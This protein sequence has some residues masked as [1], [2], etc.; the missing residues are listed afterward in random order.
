ME[1][2]G[3]RV[4]FL[5]LT[6][7]ARRLALSLASP[8]D[9]RHHEPLPENGFVEQH[10]HD[11]DFMYVMEGS[12]CFFFV[13]PESQELRGHPLGEKQMFH[14][15]V[16]PKGVLHRWEHARAGAQ[17]HDIKGSEK[18]LQIFQPL[19]WQPLGI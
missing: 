5:A 6:P 19:V 16:I 8:A 1:S 9:Q 2:T 3:L 10:Q 15:V 12:A 11:D 4:Q 13:D 7:G 18:I 17:I 14:A